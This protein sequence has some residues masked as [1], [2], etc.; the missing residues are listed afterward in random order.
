M[1]QIQM[2][3]F[4]KKNRIIL[5]SIKQTNQLSRQSLRLVGKFYSSLLAVDFK[6]DTENDLKV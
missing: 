2:D 6:L 4:Q 1:L 3:W 5:L